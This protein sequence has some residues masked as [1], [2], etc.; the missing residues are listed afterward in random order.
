[1]A[2]VAQGV[3][4]RHIQHPGVLRT[5][6]RVA[7]D[8]AF[9]LD[10]G[11]LVDER[12]ARLRMALG[13]DSVLIGGGLQVIVPEGSVRIV[14]IAAADRAFVYRMM[15]GHIEGRLGVGVA[16]EAELGLFGLQQVL[17]RLRSVDAVAA[18]AAD[19]GFGMRGAVEVGVRASMAAETGVVDL[20]GAH[21]AEA[22]N[23]RDVATALDVSLT[24][25]V[26]AFARDTLAG[27]LESETSMRI[28]AEI[29]H[30]IRVTSGAGL[31]TDEVRRVGCR[32]GLG[33]CRLL[34][35]TAGS[36]RQPGS[37]EPGQ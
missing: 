3:D 28:R 25:T 30:D 23:L 22:A 27:M 1:V 9:R 19:V 20:F 15:E 14:A 13:A 24:G 17:G 10:R 11:V 16:L 33:S 5:M 4:R 32:F 8:A 18:E 34:L 2:L 26:A 36:E 7:T 35:A 12:P 21:L 6:G 37:C 29:L 31:L